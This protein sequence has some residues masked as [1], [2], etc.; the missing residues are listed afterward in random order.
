MLVH[1][2]CTFAIMLCFPSCS[3]LSIYS[4]GGQVGGSPGEKGGG[5]CTGGRR[6]GGGE[7][8]EIGEIR[9]IAQYSVIKKAQ[10]GGSQ[11]KCGGEQGLKG[12]GGGK[13][14]PPVPPHFIHQGYGERASYVTKQRDGRDRDASNTATKRK[15]LRLLR[16]FRALKL[17]QYK[18]LRVRSI[19]RK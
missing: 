5:R 3:S 17:N 6:R 19:V 9:N 13:F 12:M 8:G 1:R 16:F 4:G 11:Q 18:R 15:N 7:A 2:D 10:R 14:E